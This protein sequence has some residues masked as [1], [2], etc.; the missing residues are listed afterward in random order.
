MAGHYRR[1]L[2]EVAANPRLVI[3][4]INLLDDEERRLLVE[5]WAGAT[6]VY[7]DDLCVHTLVE[8]QAAQRPDDIALVFEDKSI[9]YAEPDGRPNQLARSLRARPAAAPEAVVALLLR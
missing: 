4:Q 6:T 7:G 2:E 9:T 8:Q 5:D 3:D 1:L